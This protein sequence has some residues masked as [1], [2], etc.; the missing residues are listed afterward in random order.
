MK[1]FLRRLLTG[2][3]LAF[4]LTGAYWGMVRVPRNRWAMYFTH[5]DFWAILALTL[6]GGTILG[7]GAFAV[8]RLFPRAKPLLAASF[9]GW[10]ALAFADN[11][12]EIHL[13]IAKRMGWSWL[14]GPVWWLFVWG[15]GA[16]GTAGALLS[17]RW[18]RVSARAWHLLRLLLWPVVLFVP[19]SVWRLPTLDAACGKGLDFSRV[20]GNGTPATVV[21]LFDM[22]G[23][24]EVFDETRN[25]NP[26]YTNF[27]SLC[28]RS[29]VFHA[30]ESAGE[31]TSSSL[32]GFILQ[33]RLASPP[34][35]LRIRM[36]EWVF[37]DGTETLHPADF[38]AQS[39]PALARASGG[40]AQAVGMYVPWDSILPGLWDAT[41]SMA[42]EYGNH[43]CHVFGKAP[44]LTTAAKEHFTRYFVYFSKSPLSAAFKLAGGDFRTEEAYDERVSLVARA[45]RL[46]REALS[47]GDFFFIHVDMPHYPHVVGRGAA[48]LPPSF[49]LD[50]VAG[51]AAQ[52]EGADWA[53]GVWLD[54]IASSPAGRDAWVIATSDHNVHSRY[55]KGA[56]THVP[57]VVHRPGQT[58]RRDFSAPADL[59]DRRHVVPDLPLFANGAE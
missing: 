8:E 36:D 25:V 4:A 20:P 47:P 30:A 1:T 40:R 29:D 39:L 17:S 14:K 34:R 54:A 53:L 23:Y 49:Y 42:F 37:T 24:G 32:P 35:R 59:T 44:S 33:S 18:Q 27:A 52:A 6:A 26:A 57:F 45:G 12:P 41:E 55:R 56:L 21:L 3:I 11:F 48:R 10:L 5:L 19:F 9:W 58:E 16:L 13:E 38:A 22:W 43:G 2:W 7:L 15:A 51:R 50:E 28:T 31:K 46:L